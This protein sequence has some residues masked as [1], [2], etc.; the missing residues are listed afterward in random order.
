MVA[1]N[2]LG[3]ESNKG[4]EHERVLVDIPQRTD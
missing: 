1:L 4:T 3:A 2:I